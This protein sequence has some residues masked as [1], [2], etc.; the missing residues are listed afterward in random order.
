MLGKKSRYGTVGPDS[1]NIVVQKGLGITDKTSTINRLTGPN[2]LFKPIKYVN[3]DEETD[4][5][6]DV[7]YTD[8]SMRTIAERLL[9]SNRVYG[10]PTLWPGGVD[11][12]FTES[13]D[14]SKDV[15]TGGDG[16]PATPYS[17]N[18]APPF[19]PTFSNNCK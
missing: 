2:G 9:F 5:K 7:E 12:M 1:V 13:P 16:L 14:I 10:D 11:R 6:V 17:P 19:I 4:I 18:P 15:K 8:A 3:E